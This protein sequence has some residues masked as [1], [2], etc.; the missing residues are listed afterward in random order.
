[1]NPIIFFCII[2][3]VEPLTPPNSLPITDQM[4][5]VNNIDNV[6]T[7]S[8][9]SMGSDVLSHY[10]PISPNNSETKF[11]SINTVTRCH[12]KLT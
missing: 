5:I 4:H 3:A 9:C 8:A 6:H 11:H 1:M 2:L 10:K 12:T 7:V